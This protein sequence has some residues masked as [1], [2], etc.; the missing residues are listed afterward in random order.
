MPTTDTRGILEIENV[1]KSY[2][3][4]HGARFGYPIAD[5]WAT[6]LHVLHLRRRERD[7]EKFTQKVGCGLSVSSVQ[8]HEYFVNFDPVSAG[9]L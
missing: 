7:R 4:E 3:Q 2:T 8:Q 6:V 9:H 5:C 1:G